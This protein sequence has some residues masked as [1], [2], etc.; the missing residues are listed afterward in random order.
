[1]EKEEDEGEEGWTRRRTA[2]EK[3]HFCLINTHTYNKR[4]TLLLQD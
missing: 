2:E 4:L 3:I 1:M